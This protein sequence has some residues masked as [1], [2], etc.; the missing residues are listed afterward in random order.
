ME[1]HKEMNAN[2]VKWQVQ[3]DNPEKRHSPGLEVIR[4]FFLEEV[5]PGL[6]FERQLEATQAQ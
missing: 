5:M 6:N 4:E 3:K 1:G 2:N